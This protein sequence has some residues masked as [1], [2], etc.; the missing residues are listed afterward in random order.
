MT[1]MA[2]ANK[3]STLNKPFIYYRTD[4]KTN[5]TGGVSKDLKKAFNVN[6]QILPSL[7]TNLKRLGLYDTYR[8]WFKEKIKN[9]FVNNQ[10]RE[11]KDIIKNKLSQE[12]Y[13]L[14]YNTIEESPLVSI[15]LTIYNTNIEYL[16]QCLDSILKQTY[17]NFEIIAIDDCSS[18]DYSYILKLSPK[19][20]LIKNTVNLGCSKNTK[21]GFNLAKG[22]YIVKI[23]SSNCSYIVI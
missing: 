11:S 21:K 5:L 7:Y 3:I 4:Q 16:N 18:I 23:D 8:V 10:D 14:I 9:T 1:A 22:D 15:I 6:L 20:R 2:A 19:I 17:Q 12:L 13:N